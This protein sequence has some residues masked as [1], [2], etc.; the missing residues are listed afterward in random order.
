MR[1][2]IGA[3]SLAFLSIEGLYR[4][5]GEKARNPAQPQFTDHC[6]TGEYPTPLTDITD[7]TVATPRRLSMLAEAD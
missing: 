1:A 3:D 6:F 7:L 4:S 2:Y 5:M